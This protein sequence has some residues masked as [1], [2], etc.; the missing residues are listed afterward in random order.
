MVMKSGESISV[1]P[2]I[3]KN[4]EMT[5]EESD[6]EIEYEV[7]SRGSDEPWEYVGVSCNEL[8]STS[9]EVGFVEEQ[10]TI[11]SSEDLKHETIGEDKARVDI[12]ASEAAAGA[13]S[14]HPIDLVS[15][16]GTTEEV[17]F[18]S[19]AVGDKDQGKH[20][21]SKST[22][23][24]EVQENTRGN[25]DRDVESDEDSYYGHENLERLM[26]EIGSMRANL[27]LMPDV[28]RREMAAKLAMKMASMFGENSDDDG[29][30]D[31]VVA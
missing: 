28:Q 1:L 31:Q 5:D 21:E 25:L 27:R 3:T 30:F 7:L 4:E 11:S 24:V 15:E 26:C 20:D 29:N 10:I 14:S 6:Y 22:C 12:P 2:P 13:S 9:G 23:E 19:G 8:P 18:A 16:T 17:G